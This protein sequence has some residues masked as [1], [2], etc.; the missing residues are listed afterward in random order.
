MIERRFTGRISTS[1]KQP[2]GVVTANELMNIFTVAS[3]NT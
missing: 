2:I 3:P 1:R